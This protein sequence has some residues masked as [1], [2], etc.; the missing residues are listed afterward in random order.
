MPVIIA[1]NL[2]F[3]E[4]LVAIDSD[5][6]VRKPRSLLTKLE[7]VSV[8]VKNIDDENAKAGNK[9]GNE[10]EDDDDE[11]IDGLWSK[12]NDVFSC[13]VDDEDLEE[14][15]EGRKKKKGE[16]KRDTY[17]DGEEEEKYEDLDDP[18]IPSAKSEY[19]ND[20][21]KKSRKKGRRVKYQ[22]YLTCKS[23]GLSGH[24]CSYAAVVVRQKKLNPFNFVHDFYSIE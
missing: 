3:E 21:K 16:T 19:E 11:F 13:Y 9:E 2:P 6:E 14:A 1:I 15:N 12:G 24:L 4:G 23:W 22:E 10:N 7:F 5:E 17:D 8:F 20:G 18:S